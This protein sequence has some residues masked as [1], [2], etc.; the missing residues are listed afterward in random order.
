M[1]VVIGA[2]ILSFLIANLFEIVREFIL[3]GKGQ[4]CYHHS[5][6]AVVIPVRLEFSTDGI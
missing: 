6:E 3:S 2:D 4:P 5:T 1:L